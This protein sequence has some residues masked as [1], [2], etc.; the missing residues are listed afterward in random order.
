[1]ADSSNRDYA[2]LGKRVLSLVSELYPYVKHR[3]YT[4]ESTGIVP[5]NMYKM[6]GV[7]D[8]ALVDL[9]E[10]KEGYKK[11]DEELKLCMFKLVSERLDNLYKDESFH[12]DTISTSKLLQKELE[13]FEEVFEIDIDNDLLMREELTDISYHQNDNDQSM[14]LYKDAE[15]NIIKTLNIQDNNS[16]LSEEKSER[17]NKIYNWLPFETSNIL[18]LF[19][20]GKLNYDEI[21]YIKDVDKE[22]VKST[23][24]TISRN[25]RKNL[26]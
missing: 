20:F 2:L 22:I 7:I 19:V 26:N 6:Q 15:N 25:L 12:K 1:M 9:F 11:N 13:K 14:I 18:D 16:N 23:I 8:D 4:V 24:Q 17:L 5:R 3:L 21:A 10:D